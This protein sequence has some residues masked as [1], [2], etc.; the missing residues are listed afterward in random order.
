MIPTIPEICAAFAIL[1]GFGL[2]VAAAAMISVALA[3]LASGVIL[4]FVGAVA[5]SLIARV[6]QADRARGVDFPRAA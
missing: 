4:V 1:L 2:V 6:S 3:L 5:L